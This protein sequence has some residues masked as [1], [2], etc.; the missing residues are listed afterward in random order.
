MHGAYLAY[1]LYRGSPRRIQGATFI[2]AFED[3]CRLVRN[4]NKV[5]A[6]R[7]NEN[8]LSAEELRKFLSIFAL[9]VKSALFARFWLL[10][11]GKL[12]FG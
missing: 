7:L 4:T 5:S 6:Y 1:F 9:I 8:D 12:K 10:V 2:S 11:E 3:L